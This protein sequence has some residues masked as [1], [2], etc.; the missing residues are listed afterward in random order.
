MDL[1]SD[2]RGFL[3]KAAEMGMANDEF[4]F[5]LLGMRSYGFGRSGKGKEVLSNGLAPF[6]ED[7]SSDNADG[8]DNVAKLAARYVIVLDLNSDGV[9]QTY[10]SYFKN[11]V[12]AKVREDP[13]FCRTTECLT[14][15][16]ETEGAFAR[17]LH[18]TFYAYGLGLTRQPQYYHDAINIT[19][20]IAV[21]FIG[22]KLCMSF[23]FLEWSR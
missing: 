15:S 18:D 8:M 4:V 16:N 23:S 12:L 19:Q 1:A 6:W 13:L 20:A 3:I 10:M 14:N 11:M 9:N 17:H 21:D 2:R 7:G 22:K 5:V